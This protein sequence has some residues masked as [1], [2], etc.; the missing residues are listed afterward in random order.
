[1]TIL[2]SVPPPVSVTVTSDPVSPIQP[3]IFPTVT[4]TCTV[5]LSPAVD[6]PVTVNTVWTGPDGFMTTNTAQPVTGRTTTYTSTAVVSSF[7]RDQSGNYTCSA[8][9]TS[10]SQYLTDSSKSGS[11]NVT[12]G[13][14][15]SNDQMAVANCL[16][17]TC[18]SLSL[19]KWKYHRE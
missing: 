17:N 14:L 13:K 9:V 15:F 4:L 12:T 11:K 3:F 18:R 5:E 1:M 7:G 8:T 19:S 16:I 6:V 2:L 10:N